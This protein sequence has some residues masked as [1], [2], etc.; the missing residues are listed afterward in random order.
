LTLNPEIVTKAQRVVGLAKASGT[1]ITLFTNG[2]PVHAV[3][4]SLVFSQAGCGADRFAQGELTQAEHD[5]LLEAVQRWRL[6]NSC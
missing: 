6:P 1:E 4:A 2:I 5:E 3:V